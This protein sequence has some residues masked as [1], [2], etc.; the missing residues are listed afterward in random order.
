MDNHETKRTA[1]PCSSTPWCAER[2]TLSPSSSTNSEIQVTQHQTPTWTPLELDDE[3]HDDETVGAES[4]ESPERTDVVI[5][6]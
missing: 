5:T 1:A 6:F 4:V 3:G 2:R